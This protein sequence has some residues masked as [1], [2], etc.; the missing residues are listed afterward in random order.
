MEQTTIAIQGMSCGH[1]VASVKGALSRLDGVEVQEVKVGSA[2]VAY[3]PQAVTPERIT[4]AISDEG[5]AAQVAG[6]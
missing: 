1:C 6:S 4:Q 3:D 2:K 5:Y